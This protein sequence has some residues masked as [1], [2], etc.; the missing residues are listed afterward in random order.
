[1]N[2]IWKNVKDSIEIAAMG[3]I[4][5]KR[6]VSKVWFNNICEKAIQ[7]RKAAHEE[8]LKNTENETKRIRFI[9]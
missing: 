3:V 5:T 6:N 4:G 9:T 8:W 1:V 2:E 7:R